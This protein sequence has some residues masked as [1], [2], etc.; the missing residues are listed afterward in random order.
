MANAG[1]IAWDKSYETGIEEIDDQHR[2]LVNTLAEAD[3]KLTEDT[4]LETLEAI[5]K[6]LLSYALYHFETEEEMMQEYDYKGKR[7]EEFDFHMK[8][9]RSFSAKVVEIRES[10]KMGNPVDKEELIAFLTNWLINHI[11]K[12]DKKLGSFL[13]EVR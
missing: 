12:T 1:K 11:N 9:H 6:D 13:A 10:I 4:S 3:R 2:I 5:T 7:P 8:Q